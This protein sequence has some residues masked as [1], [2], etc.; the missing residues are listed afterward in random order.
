MRIST[1]S[2]F[3]T[4]AGVDWMAESKA[5][6]GAKREMARRYHPTWLWQPEDLS[7]G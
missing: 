2:A 1:A 6:E 7:N 3:W 5:M 4:E